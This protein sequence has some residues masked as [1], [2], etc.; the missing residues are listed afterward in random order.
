MFKIQTK[1][2]QCHPDYNFPKCICA[3][4]VQSGMDV[5]VIDICDNNQL[6]DFVACADGTLS[7]YRESDKVYK[8]CFKLALRIITLFMFQ[9][10]RIL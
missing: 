7:F 9:M 8:V 4:S 5:F 6:I 10:F 2:H 1:H 3:V